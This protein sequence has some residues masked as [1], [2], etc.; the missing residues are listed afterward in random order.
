LKASPETTFRHLTMSTGVIN[1]TVRHST[2]SKSY[3][4]LP[5]KRQTYALY[6]KLTWQVNK[7]HAL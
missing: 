2:L 3:L 4:L 1:T 7:K 5:A 6:S